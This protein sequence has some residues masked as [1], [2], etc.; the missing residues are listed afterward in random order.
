MI[1]VEDQQIIDDNI[2]EAAALA[3]EMKISVFPVTLSEDRVHQRL[4]Y[5]QI[6][7]YAYKEPDNGIAGRVSWGRLGQDNVDIPPVL[8][9]V[10]SQN[11]IGCI[12]GERAS[13]SNL[14]RGLHS[15]KDSHLPIWRNDRIRI[16]Q[17]DEFGLS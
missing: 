7:P 10:R 8:T 16:H 4:R 3:P 17:D 9:I 14:L 11:E 12:R 2:L 1:T 13:Q 5:E 15:I 6:A